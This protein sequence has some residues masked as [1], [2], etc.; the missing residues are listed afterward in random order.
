MGIRDA[1]LGMDF[2]YKIIN[3]APAIRGHKNKA[4]HVY[5]KTSI[6]QFSSY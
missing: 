5:Q 1:G 6:A 3:P 2:G 4:I